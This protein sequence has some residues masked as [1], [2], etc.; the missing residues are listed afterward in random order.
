M[1]ASLVHGQYHV[2]QE[3]MTTVLRGDAAEDSASAQLFDIDGI[4][5]VN[6]PS[7]MIA[8]ETFG[9]TPTSMEAYNIH[10]YDISDNQTLVAHYV[11]EED[12]WEVLQVSC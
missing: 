12:R 1:L 8:G 9:T 6:G 7:N 3:Y 11:R 2:V 4:N 5:G 10:A